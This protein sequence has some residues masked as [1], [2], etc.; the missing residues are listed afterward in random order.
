MIDWVIFQLHLTCPDHH[1]LLTSHQYLGIS[2]KHLSGKG[3]EDLAGR[4]EQLR[5]KI[6]LFTF[7]E[8]LYT[9]RPQRCTHY[10][11]RSHSFPESQADV[12][13][14]RKAKILSQPQDS[15]SYPRRNGRKVG[16]LKIHDV[17]NLV[18]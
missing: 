3:N 1:F 4:Q 8:E 6:V 18:M 12:G 14:A 7:F 5:D 15:P 9:H 11:Q 13:Q 17:G 16:R 2:F 10:P